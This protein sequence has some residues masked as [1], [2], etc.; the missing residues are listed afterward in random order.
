MN[1]TEVLNA[2]RQASAFDLY[3]LRAAIDRTLDEPKW[4]RAINTALH[5]GQQVEYFDARDNRV[6]SG[7]VL[8]LRQKTALLLRKDAAQRWL[9]PYA[10]INLDGV[11]ST[12]RDNPT[13]GLGRHEVAVGDM[14]GFYDHDQRQRNG[15]IIRLNDKTV[16]IITQDQRWRVAYALLHR[17]M[18]GDSTEIHGDIISEL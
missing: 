10:A 8:E 1:Y 14:V 2:L 3:R 5:V 15:R 6:Y 16:T 18:D 11:D 4:N 17:I 12:I 7:V 9:I 13:H